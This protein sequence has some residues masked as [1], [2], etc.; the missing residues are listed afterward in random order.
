MLMPTFSLTL[1][2]YIE[3]N[4]FLFSYFH[5]LHPQL[6]KIISEQG[7][8]YNMSVQKLCQ[9]TSDGFSEAALQLYLV[10]PKLDST[11]ATV[12]SGSFLL[13]T[14]IINGQVRSRIQVF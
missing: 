12:N 7:I 4:I 3:A 14:M 13:K 6:L 11:K 5:F 9:L 10:T 2:I 1:K 8:F